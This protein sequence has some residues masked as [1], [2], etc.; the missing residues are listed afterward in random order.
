MYAIIGCCITRM[1]PNRGTHLTMP[2]Q[3]MLGIRSGDGYPQSFPIMYDSLPN[4]VAIACKLVLSSWFWYKPMSLLK[5]NSAFAWPITMLLQSRLVVGSRK[6][7]GRLNQ[8]TMP[9]TVIDAGFTV[10]LHNYNASQQIEIVLFCTICY[11]K[12][13]FFRQFVCANQNKPG[14]WKY[15][16]TLEQELVLSSLH[17]LNHSYFL[18]QHMYEELCPPAWVCVQTIHGFFTYRYL[19]KGTILRVFSSHTHSSCL[20]VQLQ[21]GYTHSK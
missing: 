14:T 16:K 15:L 4:S 2:L 21:L 13:F 1:F 17:I 7:N 6:N 9:R 3:D 12:L 20:E 5:S 8:G 11:T 18:S 10:I 19:Q